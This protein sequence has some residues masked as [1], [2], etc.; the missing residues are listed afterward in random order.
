MKT[1]SIGGIHPS[2]NKFAK[3]QAFEQFPI[4]KKVTVFL[5]QNLGAPPAIQVKK[6]DF[7][8][9]GQV[10]AKAEAFICANLHAPVSG[11]VSKIELVSNGVG[12][13]K[14]AIT[15]DVEGDEWLETIDT[16][17][18]IEREIKLERQEIINRIKEC[19]IVGLG[20]AC[21]PTFVK[22]MVPPD[23]NV[24]FL[25]INAAECE[26]YITVDHRFMIERA[27]ECLIGISALMKAAGAPKAMVGIEN[28]K[29]D[30]I[31]HFTKVAEAYP[32]IEICA[33]KTKYPQGSEKQLIKSLVNRE[34]PDGKL[35]I[36]VGVIVNNIATC[37]AV[38]EAVQ[39]NKPLI[40][41][42]LT[43]SGKKME[44]FKNYQVRIGTSVAEIL[45]TVGIPENTGK[46]VAGGPMMGKAMAT[47]DT[48][49]VKGM[50]SLLL[51]DMDEAKRGEIRNCIRCGKCVIACPMGLEPNLL[52]TL[53]KL[54]NYEEG[55]KHRITACIECGSCLYTC[56]A[57]RPLIDYI[58]VGKGKAMAIRAAAAKKIS[59]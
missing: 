2:D 58:R 5:H 45:E 36:E 53:S 14:E 1:F 13:K 17:A 15:I 4:P 28:N 30:C 35:P 37:F 43:V 38:Y 25:L 34:V 29:K 49:A 7:V 19:G 26:P 42:Y 20:G 31:E 47:I 54:G 21:F 57:H 23:K 3:N 50:T 6:G 52:S 27:E 56:P 33:L 24:D 22:Y 39:K 10:L 11:K 55:D 8:K 9:V 51:I 12:F 40:E 46:I 32:N 59:N 48:F 41:T 16:S 18:T 44:Q